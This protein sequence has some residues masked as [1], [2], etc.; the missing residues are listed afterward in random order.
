[1]TTTEIIFLVFFIIIPKT[2]FLGTIIESLFTKNT[3][4]E[5]HLKDF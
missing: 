1:M 2:I 3:K 5:N 4:Q